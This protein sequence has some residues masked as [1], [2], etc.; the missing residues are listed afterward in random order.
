MSHIFTGEMDQ[1]SARVST[2]AVNQQQRAVQVLKWPSQTATLHHMEMQ[3]SVI[4]G[5]SL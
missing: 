3:C 4:T 5:S 2:P 1:R